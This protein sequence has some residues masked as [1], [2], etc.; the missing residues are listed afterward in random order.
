MGV[1]NNNISTRY[2]LVFFNVG[3]DLKWNIQKQKVALL[4]DL[5]ELLADQV[6]VGL[7]VGPRLLQTCTMR[8]VHRDD[9]NGL[10]GREFCF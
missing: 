2:F 5:T 8:L 10:D 6:P 9:I 1:K 3:G 7:A 4:C